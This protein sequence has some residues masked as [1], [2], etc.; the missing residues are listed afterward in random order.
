MLVGTSLLPWGLFSMFPVGTFSD[1]CK[2]FQSND[3]LW[4]AL[5]NALGDGMV[6]LQ[7]QPS[8]SST[9]DH[10]ASGSGTSAFT[11]QA[12]SDSN[13]MVGLGAYRF[14]RIESGLPR[15]SSS[16]HQ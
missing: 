3:A 15:W 12:F 16:H 14:A 8:L 11:L 5:D 7:L 6:G 13:I 9:D 2:M 4:V 1:V 10:K